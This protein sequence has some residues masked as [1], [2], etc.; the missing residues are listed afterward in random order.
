MNRRPPAPEARRWCAGGS[1]P[2][3]NLH[4]DPTS[5]LAL[6]ISQRASCTRVERLVTHDA[7]ANVSENV[8][9]LGSPA[10]WPV[11]HVHFRRCRRKHTLESD[12]ERT[13]C[14]HSLS[15]LGCPYRMKTKLRFVEPSGRIEGSGWE[16][17]SP[18]SF[19][20]FRATAF[21]P[22]STCSYIPQ[23]CSLLVPSTCSCQWSSDSCSAEPRQWTTGG[24]V[25]RVR[26]IQTSS[27]NI[28]S[29]DGTHVE[30]RMGLAKWLARRGAV[31]GTA[32]WAAN[33]YH[34]FRRRHSDSQ[35]FPDSA[36]YRLM[37]VTKI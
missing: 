35:E 6:L 37:I 25:L 2:L 29:T 31:G 17:P 18:R 20:A 13:L 11:G 34:F 28:Y 26:R 8:S 19:G 22:L 32:Q 10:R 30:V 7:H 9:D 21:S 1:W 16:S 36:I 33:G 15:S 27:T 5:F 23:P 14:D 24:G 12:T 3:R 4:R